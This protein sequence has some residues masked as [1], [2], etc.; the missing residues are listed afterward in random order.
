[1]LNR[2]DEEVG[3]SQ[4][5]VEEIL[6]MKVS[7]SLPSATAVASAT[8]HGQ[9]IVLSKPDHPVSKAIITLARKVAGDSPA[10]KQEAP[11]RPSVACSVARRSARRAR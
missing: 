5:N 1:M 9:P 2:A 11:S 7:I 3:L 6:G 4:A 8:N 10:L